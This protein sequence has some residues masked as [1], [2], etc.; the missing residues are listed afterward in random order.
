MT[1]LL[2]RNV[3]LP[4]E[5]IPVRTVAVGLTS[6]C[7][8]LVILIALALVNG[9]LSGHIFWLPLVILLQALFLIGIV[10]IV[11]AVSI[12]LPDTSYFVNLSVLLLMF[13]SPIGFK[14]DMVPAGFAPIIY[15]NP[16]HYMAD[17]FRTSVLANH[18]LDTT[19]LGIYA[20]ICLC[21]FAL[22]TAFFRRFKG[23]LVDYE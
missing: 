18:A 23:V 2:I 21:T 16:V 19:N 1:D 12:A 7:V 4:I 13:I 3:M 22:G 20:L 10:L 17:A 9:S 6:Q 8:A 14:P 15:L 11:S 5:L